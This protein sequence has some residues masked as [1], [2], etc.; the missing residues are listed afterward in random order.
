MPNNLSLTKTKVRELQHCLIHGNSGS[1]K[2]FMGKRIR[3]YEQLEYM[4]YVR[5]DNSH[6]NL[7]GTGTSQFE[8][9]EEGIIVAVKRMKKDVLV[10]TIVSMLEL[11]EAQKKGTPDA[12]IKQ[13]YA[14]MKNTI[15][16]LLSEGNDYGQ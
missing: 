5:K 11:V 10:T 3:V 14:W 16:R 9:T 12:D 6:H 15:I 4:G 1:V 13:Q 7:S 2:N 8:L